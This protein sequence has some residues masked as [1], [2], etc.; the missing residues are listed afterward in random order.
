MPINDKHKKAHFA[1]EGVN[2]F[3]DWR[4]FLTKVNKNIYDITKSEDKQLGEFFIKP[5]EGHVI[6]SED[7]RSK[8]MFYLWDSI[9]KDEEGN[10]TAETVFHFKIAEGRDDKMTFQKLFD[11]SLE[12]GVENGRRYVETILGEEHLN[13][14][15]FDPDEDNPRNDEEDDDNDAPE[16]AAPEVAADLGDGN[17]AG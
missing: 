12:D 6:K 14:K 2:S 11:K 16:N 9:Y 13:V 17:H 8:V 3:Y 7:F 1:I 5:K 15:P 4:D 10:K